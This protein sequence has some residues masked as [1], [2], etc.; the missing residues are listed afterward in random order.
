MR[1]LKGTL[2]AVLF[3]VNTALFAQCGATQKW[4]EGKEAGLII[5]NIEDYRVVEEDLKDSLRISAQY[6]YGSVG[7]ALTNAVAPDFSPL[8]AQM[9]LLVV[10]Q[11][12]SNK[13][14][15]LKEQKELLP[16][17]EQEG[18]EVWANMSGKMNALLVAK[19]EDDKV[20]AFVLFA[21]IDGNQLML[22]DY[23]GEVDPQVLMDLMNSDGVA[24]E[25]LM[26]LNQLNFSI[27]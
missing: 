25:Q 12:I 13:S 27:D 16:D 24:F 1:G 9:K 2:C 10:A 6:F 3:L 18:F 20:K 26:N 17:L 5:Q 8:T 22:V 11:G 7:R 4:L 15:F 21:L 14:V 23:E 19:Q